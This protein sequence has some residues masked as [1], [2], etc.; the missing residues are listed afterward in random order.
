M[1]KS[2]CT[3][4]AKHIYT[5]FNTNKRGIYSAVFKAFN[6]KKCIKTSPEKVSNDESCKF[7]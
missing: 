6:L 5:I 4:S 3:I 1:R 7:V 2:N